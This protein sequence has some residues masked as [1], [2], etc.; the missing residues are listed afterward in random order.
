[1]EH[2]TQV[3]GESE[4]SNLSTLHLSLSLSPS[5]EER[6]SRVSTEQRRGE[7][8]SFL[9]EQGKKKNKGKKIL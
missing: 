8:M 6:G 2:G 7:K 9:Y 4:I 1:M 3:C 5:Q